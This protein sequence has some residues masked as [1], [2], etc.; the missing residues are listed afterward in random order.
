MKKIKQISVI[1]LGLLGASVTLAIKRCMPDVRT[2]GYAH[3]PS[4][5]EKARDFDVAD[6]VTDDLG[7]AVEN[8]D[9][10]ILATPIGKFQEYFEGISEFVKDGC[11]VTDVGSTKQLAHKW[12]KKS[13]TKRAHYVGSHPI[14]GSEKRGLEFAR[15]DLFNN[16]NCIITSDKSSNRAAVKTL[17]EFW[18]NL[19]SIIYEMTA[20]RHDKMLG[21]ISHLPHLM[22]AALVNA[23]KFEDLKLAGRG[24][25]DTSRIASGPP[26]VWTDIFMTNA[27]NTAT[28]IDKVIKQL[29]KLRDAITA[30]DAKKIER[31]L[32]NA[33][34]K[35][36]ELIDYKIQ[37]GEILT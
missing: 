18:S 35:R 20:A 7:E 13:L 34:V 28:D 23:S 2:A 11:I 10:V 5:C 1:G 24:F 26:N 25:L 8:A 6:I 37:K 14:A 33:R 16:A 15:D 21:S 29:E 22:A 31:L 32:D 17:Y 3:R 9:I 27:K 36:A 30:N 19:G 12:A 4:T